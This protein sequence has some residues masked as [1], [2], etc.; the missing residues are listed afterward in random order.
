[1][2]GPVADRDSTA[3]LGPDARAAELIAAR[4]P[5]HGRVVILGAGD[6][7][8]AAILSGMRYAVVAVDADPEAGRAARQAGFAGGWLCQAPSDLLI[9]GMVFDL[10]VLGPDVV[11]E[12][13]RSTLTPML[14][15]VS[16][17]LRPGGEVFAGFPLVATAASD[18]WLLRDYDRACWAADL[19]YVARFA[20]W[21][22][23]PFRTGLPYAVSVHRAG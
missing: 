7:K 17:H 22:G 3:P 2:S 11:T 9:P 21:L 16:G 10:A 23:T 18:A 1:M 12:R 8:L 20:D 19:S 4:H 6:G 14:T 13:A 5:R 15:R